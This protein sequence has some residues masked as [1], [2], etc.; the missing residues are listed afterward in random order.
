MIEIGTELPGFDRE[1]Y[2]REIAALMARNYNLAIGELDTGKVLYELINISFQRGLRL[3]A[4]LTL[5]AKTL[6]N[7]DAVTKSIDPTYSPIPT[8][9]EYGAQI[10]TDRAR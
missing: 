7:L 1:A 3:P 5:L 9:R 4:E 8:I 6:F 2:V 10:A